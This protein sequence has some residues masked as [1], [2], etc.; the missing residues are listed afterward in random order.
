MDIENRWRVI[1]SREACLEK[2]ERDIRAKEEDIRQFMNV[3]PPV[4][5]AMQTN[6][7]MAQP[8]PRP[9]LPPKHQKQHTRHIKK[10]K[11]F[12]REDKD[13]SRFAVQPRADTEHRES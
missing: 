5:V 2:R 13:Y 10:A 9:L 8:P 4:A 7:H 1:A 3:N 11:I 12:E 6:M